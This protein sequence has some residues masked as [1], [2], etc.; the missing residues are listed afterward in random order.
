M[1]LEECPGTI[2]VGWLCGSDD[3]RL[4]RIYCTSCRAYGPHFVRTLK[5]RR[6]ILETEPNLTRV[7]C[8]ECGEALVDGGR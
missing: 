4:R 1:Q 5:T 8:S 3:H 6:A 7:T 2:V